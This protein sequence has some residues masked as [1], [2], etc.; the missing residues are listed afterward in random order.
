[1]TTFR[2]LH[3]G[4]TVTPVAGPGRDGD[5]SIDV[6]AVP[7]TV[8]GCVHTDLLSAGRIDDPYLNDNE[9]RLRWIGLTDW[10]YRTAFAWGS[11]DFDHVELVCEGLDTVAELVL[12]GVEI[13]RT[14]NMHRTY[15]FDVTRQLQAGANELT[16]RFASAYQYAASEQRRLGDRPNAYADA[17]FNFIRKMAANFG[18]DWGPALTTCGIWKPIGLHS[19]SVA[20][21]GAV[22]PRLSV[23]GAHGTVEVD[24]DLVTAGDG[25]VVVSASLGGS[26]VR[27]VTDSAGAQ[28]ALSVDD[29]R[30]WHPRGAGEQALYDL[31]VTLTDL[32]G[33][34]LDSWQRRVGFRSVALD[35]ADDATGSAYT[36]RV[37]E[38]PIWIRGVNWITDDCFPTRITRER[39]AE[40]FAQC[41]DANVN[42][43]RVWGGGIYESEDFYELADE[44]G[45]LVGQDF[46]F[47]CA[48]YPEE[49]PHRSEVLAEAEDNVTRLSSHPSLVTWTGNNENIWGHEDW[50]WI[51]LLAGRTWGAGYYFDVLPDV[52]ARLDP[53]RPY[54]PG[55]PYSGNRDRHPNDPAH[56][57]MHI[58]DV[59]NTLDYRHYR[60]YVPRMAAEFGY[61][62]PPTYA[63][64]AASISDEPL[65]HDSPGMAHHQK[66]EDGDAKLRR[67]LVAHLPP[68]RTFDDWHYF[69]QLNQARAVALGVEHFRS[70]RPTCMGAIV[71]QFNDCWPV[72]SWAAVDGYGRRK[73]MWFALR[74][75]FADRLLTIQ[76]RGT[77]LVVV[78]VNDLDEAWDAD[79]AVVRY[80][81]DGSVLAKVILP[82]RVPPRAAT[83]TVLSASVSVAGDPVRELIRATAGDNVAHWFFAEDRDVDYP[84]AQWSSSVRGNRLTITARTILRDL[85]LFADR[86]ADGAE[87]DRAMVTLLPGESATFTVD[88]PDAGQLHE[89]PGAPVVRAVNDVIGEGSGGPRAAHL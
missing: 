67:G 50:G 73:L 11:E 82:V 49:E 6:V 2:A 22:R 68:P 57:T 36:L 78:L 84:K 81:L 14:C 27:I 86:L 53:T 18:W 40:R 69:T 70:H 3:E 9:D 80:D 24:V 47:A 56:G 31:E 34:P 62:G 45:L 51:P 43:L 48:A 66:A 17:P 32:D 25:P 58:W 61:Q 42:Y 35:T 59:W 37:N 21:F 52:L 23:D 38:R 63:T 1:V 79:V 8:P 33:L 12:N 72:T 87:T 44:L 29:V 46:L 54:W 19:W 60:D 26:T 39:L 65:A 13:A 76:P 74:H 16:I 10:E 89:V 64:I 30:R 55:S 75:A 85:T 83:T 71:W 77:E 41:I 7:A 20:R 4:W 88:G 5:R 28:L 15:R